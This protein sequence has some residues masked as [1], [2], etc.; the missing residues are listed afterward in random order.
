MASIEPGYNSPSRLRDGKLTFDATS[1]NGD[2]TAGFVQR[3]TIPPRRQPVWLR[4]PLDIAAE[5]RANVITIHYRLTELWRDFQTL[6][7]IE[8]HERTFETP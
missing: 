4:S 2:A 6:P 1:R 8:M 7:F 3:P 5:Y